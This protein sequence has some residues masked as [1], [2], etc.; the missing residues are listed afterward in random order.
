MDD[1]VIRA[2]RQYAEWVVVDVLDEPA[3]MGSGSSGSKVPTA[4][5]KTL[6][7]SRAALF[8]LKDDD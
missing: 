7:T 8:G 4:T 6:V 3:Q 2:L 5:Q 1:E